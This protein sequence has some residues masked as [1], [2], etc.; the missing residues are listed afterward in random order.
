METKQPE[1][2]TAAVV[3]ILHSSLDRHLFVEV[4]RRNALEQRLRRD[5]KRFTGK[6]RGR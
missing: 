3:A 2:V 1:T 6:G 4:C 5:R